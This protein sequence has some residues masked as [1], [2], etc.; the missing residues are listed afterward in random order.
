[1]APSATSPPVQLSQPR[2]DAPPPKLYTP[3][4]AHF[5]SFVE[6][7]YDGYLKA[8]SKGY[9]KATIVIDNGITPS[10]HIGASTSASDMKFN[11]IISD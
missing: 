3:K 9:E 5:E 2:E 8:K 7:Q 1:M 10:Q 6:P 4:E 11:R